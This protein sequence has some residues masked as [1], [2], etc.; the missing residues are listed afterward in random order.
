MLTA[1]GVHR[2]RG[3]KNLKFILIPLTQSKVAEL[4]CRLSG[5]A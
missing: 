2:A 1:V 4:S 5:Y 3:K